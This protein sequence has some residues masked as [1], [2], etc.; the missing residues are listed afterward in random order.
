MFWWGFPPLLNSQLRRE[1]RTAP[2]PI[3]KCELELERC[4]GGSWARLDL[5]Y[6]EFI[7]TLIQGAREGPPKSPMFCSFAMSIK[8]Y[9]GCGADLRLNSTIPQIVINAHCLLSSL[10]S[11]P[12]QYRDTHE[13]GTSLELLIVKQRCIALRICLRIWYAVNLTLDPGT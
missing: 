13:Q 5:D 7:S 11:S 9:V 3:D 4:G 10:L 2:R 1:T 12:T 6:F 8:L